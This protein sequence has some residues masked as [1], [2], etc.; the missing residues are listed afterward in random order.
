MKQMILK[1]AKYSLATLLAAVAV[2]FTW[3]YIETH[4][5]GHGLSYRVEQ[6]GGGYG[7]AT[8]YV[9]QPDIQ[10]YLNGDDGF[11]WEIKPVQITKQLAVLDFRV[12]HFNHA[13]TFEEM[14]AQLQTEPLQRLAL[15][16]D[17][18]ISIATPDG[19]TISLTGSIL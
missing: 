6:P 12:R 16:S 3:A 11:A 19:L 10:T 13:A 17:Q 4:P 2:H 7:G 8:V 18:K 5:F 9:G 14:R 15:R 1:V